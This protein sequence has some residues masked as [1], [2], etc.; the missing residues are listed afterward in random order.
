[1]R[2]I[3]NSLFMRFVFVIDCYYLFTHVKS[4]RLTCCSG[5]IST[6]TCH[7]GFSSILPRR[8]HRLLTI[9]ATAMAI[10]PCNTSLVE[11]HHKVL[12]VAALEVQMSKYVGVNYMVLRSAKFTTVAA[13]GLGDLLQF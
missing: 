13:S 10:T 3:I 4:I 11:L 8:S 5:L 7:T 6:S 9:A 2:Y 12:A 1:M